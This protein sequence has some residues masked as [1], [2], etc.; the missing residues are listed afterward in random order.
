MEKW[1]I[2]AVRKD[3]QHAFENTFLGDGWRNSLYF[4]FCFIDS[5]HL[6]NKKEISNI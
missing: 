3:Y 4:I 6:F 1:K 5:N 2:L